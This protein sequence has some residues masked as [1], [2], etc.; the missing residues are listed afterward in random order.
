[1]PWRSCVDHRSTCTNASPSG[2][3]N[4]DR[5]AVYGTSELAGLLQELALGI[6]ELF[7]FA[8]INGGEPRM[9]A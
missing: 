2:R 4:T 1:V 7:R 8:V 9:A 6:K 3:A 5:I